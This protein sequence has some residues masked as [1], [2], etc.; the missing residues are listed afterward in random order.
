MID[1]PA[2][3]QGIRIDAVPTTSNAGMMLREIHFVSSGMSSAGW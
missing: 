1:V 2:A 3:G